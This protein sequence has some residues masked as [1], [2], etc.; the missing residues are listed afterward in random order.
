MARYNREF[1]T[2][3]LTDLCALHFAKEAIKDKIYEKKTWIGKLNQG[4]SVTAPREPKYEKPIGCFSVGLILFGAVSV[5]AFIGTIVSGNWPG[6]SGFLKFMMWLVFIVGALMI[7]FPVKAGIEIKQENDALRSQYESEYRKYEDQLREVRKLNADAK[8]L[9]PK[10]IEQQRF[11]EHELEVVSDLLDRTYRVN[12]IPGRYRDIYAAVYLHDYFINSREDD[13]AMALNTYVLE[14][15]KDKLDRIIEMQS[16]I[17]L[18]QR[19]QTAL[20]YKT[21]T[22]QRRFATSMERKLARLN[23]TAEEQKQYLGMIEANTSAT[24]YFA[25]ASYFENL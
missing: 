25:A 24:A 13:L 18:N 20:Q 19:V 8:A 14:Q 6:D 5:F 16:E 3:Y 1:L 23:A 22:D 21:I 7:F 15:I 10:V 4:A 2:A 9:V 12:V 17:I 11:Y